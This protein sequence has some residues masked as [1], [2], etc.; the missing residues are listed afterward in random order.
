MPVTAMPLRAPW[1]SIHRMTL[2]EAR[3]MGPVLGMLGLVGPAW[4]E[5]LCVHVS[6][7]VVVPAAAGPCGAQ[8]TALACFPAGDFVSHVCLLFETFPQYVAYVCN[9]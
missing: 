6:Q 3:G 8:L 1:P 9:H 5:G 2:K 7:L 4:L